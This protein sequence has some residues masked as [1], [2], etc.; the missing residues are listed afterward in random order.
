MA[1]KQVL[2]EGKWLRLLKKGRW[3]FVERVNCSSVVA[4]IAVTRENEV[5]LVEQYRPA[6]G[7]RVIELPAGLVGDVDGDTSQPR[8]ARREMIE[9]TGFRPHRV[10]LLVELPASAGLTSET[11]SLYR[12]TGLRRVGEG[13]GDESENIKVHLLPIHKAADWLARR[14]ARGALVDAKVYAGFYFAGITR[15]TI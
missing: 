13:G 10:E 2:G 6:V 3:E 1:R 5:I 14:V 4:M 7:R 15:G 12:C 11:T 9:E 8:A